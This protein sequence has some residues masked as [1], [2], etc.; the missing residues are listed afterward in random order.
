MILPVE[1]V[2]CL[3]RLPEAPLLPLLWSFLTLPAFRVRQYPGVGPNLTEEVQRPLRLD[4]DNSLEISFSIP[5]YY[6]ILF[7]DKEVPL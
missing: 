3:H 6:P 2:L 4:L 5:I 7:I 1:R